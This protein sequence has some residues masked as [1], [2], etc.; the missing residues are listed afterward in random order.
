M[1]YVKKLFILI[2]TCLSFQAVSDSNNYVPG[3]KVSVKQA[4]IKSELQK[5]LVEDLN[6][7]KSMFRNKEPVVVNNIDIIEDNALN[8]A[9]I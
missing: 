4:S 9:S 8:T 1:D 5:Y 2:V 6:Q 7:I 3:F